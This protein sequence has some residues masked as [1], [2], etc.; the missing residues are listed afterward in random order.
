MMVACPGKADYTTIASRTI[1]RYVAQKTG[2]R[3]PAL[4]VQVHTSLAG[5]QDSN[6][7]K[8]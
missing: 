7:I 1:L 3:R 6:Y 4:V 8:K 5:K 2:C